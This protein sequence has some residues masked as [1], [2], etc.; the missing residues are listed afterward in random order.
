MISDKNITADATFSFFRNGFKTTSKR[1]FTVQCITNSE[2][3]QLS[4]ADIDRMKVDHKISCVAFLKRMMMQTNVLLTFQKNVLAAENEVGK[5]KRVRSPSKKM[6]LSSA[7]L[8]QHNLLEVYHHM[9]E[10][11]A[12][13]AQNY[14]SINFSS[15][16]G[17]SSENELDQ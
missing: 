2:V 14:S 7:S 1:F 11:T 16:D 13:N 5:L 3:L 17:A 9:K 4:Y 15:M 8:Q 10:F 6:T 12:L